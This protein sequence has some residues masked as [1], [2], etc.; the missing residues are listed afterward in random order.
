[1][2]TETPS[3]KKQEKENQHNHNNI[4]SPVLIVSPPALERLRHDLT[5]RR[6]PFDDSEEEDEYYARRRANVS[7]M[8]EFREKARRLSKR[9][10]KTRRE[11]DEGI[12]KFGG[13]GGSSSS[14][15]RIQKEVAGFG[16]SDS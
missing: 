13:G 6:R 12:Q 16:I 7:R 10:K 2:L 8:R 15:E 14:P 11:L 9:V 5:N 1:M 4:P 3:N